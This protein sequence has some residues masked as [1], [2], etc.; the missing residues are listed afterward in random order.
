MGP[1]VAAFLV[2]VLGLAQVF[3]GGGQA[4]MAPSP[5]TSGLATLELVG[6]NAAGA[7]TMVGSLTGTVVLIALGSLGTAAVA[8]LFLAG[9]SGS[10]AVGPRTWRRLYGVLAVVLIVS[11]AVGVVLGV[12][13]H[14]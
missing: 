13:R 9:T 14:G 11:C 3:L 4:W 5:P 12:V 6:W 1:W 2:L 8:A 10:G 7:L